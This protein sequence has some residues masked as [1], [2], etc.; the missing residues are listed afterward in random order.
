MALKRNGKYYC[1]YCYKE[2][3]QQMD[4]EACKDSHNLIYV[5]ISDTDLNRLIQFI[6][7]GNRELL[8]ESMVTNL[9]KY[10]RGVKR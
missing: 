2:F 6:Y 7:T 3:A 8:T 9:K 4:A 10:M 5:A 1:G